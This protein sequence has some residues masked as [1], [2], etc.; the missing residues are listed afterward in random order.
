MA[1]YVTLWNYTQDG[2]EDVTDS[3][4]R[5]ER[6]KEIVESVGGEVKDVYL[7][8]GRYDMVTVAE[9]PSDEAAAKAQLRI[10]SGGN[11]SSETLPAF[12]ERQFR[13]VVADLPD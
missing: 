2:I 11:V 10:G 1:T 3:P 9:F 8:F 5:V 12:T 6:G 4:D 7:T 13:D